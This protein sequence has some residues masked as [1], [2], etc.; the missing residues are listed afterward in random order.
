MGKNEYYL[1]NIL[2]NSKSDI[3]TVLLNLS[4]LNFNMNTTNS[5]SK[6]IKYYELYTYAIF[7]LLHRLVKKLV[8]GR[9]HPSFTSQFVTCKNEPNRGLFVSVNNNS[10]P[11]LRL[12]SVFK[13]SV[14]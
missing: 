1:D 5:L 13:V 9:V 3:L 4:Y 14:M 12:L 7:R 6:Y 2:S 8:E 10:I 11:F